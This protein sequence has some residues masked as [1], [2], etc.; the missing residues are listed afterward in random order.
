MSVLQPDVGRHSKVAVIGLGIGLFA[1]AY[2]GLTY[3]M[4]T[5]DR[6]SR[7]APIAEHKHGAASEETEH[8][9][10]VLEKYNKQNATSAE[11][12]GRTYI[13]VLS[14]RTEAPPEP[15]APPPAPR[16]APPQPLPP[17]APRVDAK[18]AERIAEQT[19]ALMANWTAKPHGNARTS[20][21]A[22]SYA[23]SLRSS[24]PP[25]PDAAPGSTATS[26]QASGYALIPAVLE[27]DIDTDQNSV[28]S[29]Y[30]P[31]G[32][33]AG[34]RA[35]AM[36]Y[37]LRADGVDMTFTVMQW[38]GRS[39]KIAA[40]A[41]DRHSMRSV[42]SGEVNHR[43]VSR[44]L[45]P[46]LAHGIGRT[47]ALFA[48]A[49]SRNII[50]PEG[51]VIQT[52]PETPSG[53]NIAGT[54]VGG[55]GEQAGTVLADDAAQMPVKQVTIPK[56]TTIG[57]QFIGPVIETHEERQLNDPGTSDAPANGTSD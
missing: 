15:P 31:N 47:G 2:V 16:L 54:I 5:S 19:E 37:A 13:S 42:L 57:I 29:A 8:Y 50:T 4:E 7:I 14:G 17:P 20:E 9:A 11:K 38:K 41:I 44:I 52:Y 49:S 45:L 36:G 26:K 22:A 55:A 1:V 51:G 18:R 43:Y 56:G 10:Q 53:R 21:D 23:A 6:P 27:T 30:I 39:Y 33:Y 40:K 46:A 32:E 25:R 12:D 48:N 34:A 35:Y 3:F 24:P 28:V